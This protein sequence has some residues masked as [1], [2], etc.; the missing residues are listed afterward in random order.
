MQPDSVKQYAYYGEKA[1]AEEK[2]I[3]QFPGSGKET[4]A[5]RSPSPLL[6][7]Y[8]K[9]MILIGILGQSLYYLQAFKIYMKRSAQDVSLEGF[10]IAF[11]SLACWLIYGILIKDKVLIIVNIV[12]VFGAGLASV[13][14]LSVS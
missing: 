6:Y 9:F 5:K 1:F 8:T 10:L 14:I 11:F 2:T 7:Y 4:D 3:T 13:A 12:A